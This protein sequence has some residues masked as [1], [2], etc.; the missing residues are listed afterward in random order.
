MPGPPKPFD[1]TQQVATERRDEDI[2]EMGLVLIDER[3]ADNGIALP[4]AAHETRQIDDLH[5]R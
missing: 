5:S 1:L 2:G 4:G 3:A